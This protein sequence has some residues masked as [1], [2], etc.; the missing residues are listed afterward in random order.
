[1]LNIFD[2]RIPTDYANPVNELQTAKQ[3]VTREEIKETAK[4]AKEEA[5]A[6]KLCRT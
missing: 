3:H 4:K 2:R 6:A 1:M 5:E